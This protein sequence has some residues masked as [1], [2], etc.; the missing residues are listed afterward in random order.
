MHDDPRS[1]C[2][3]TSQWDWF[4]DFEACLVFK[5]WMDRASLVDQCWDVGNVSIP[6]NAET[7]RPLW[8]LQTFT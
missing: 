7:G 2:R 4:S 8:E 1:N 6:G 3:V 5:D